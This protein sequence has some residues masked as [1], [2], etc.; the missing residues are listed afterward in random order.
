[1]MEDDRHIADAF[2]WDGSPADS[3]L[4]KRKSLMITFY[5]YTKFSLFFSSLLCIAAMQMYLSNFQTEAM[6]IML[7]VSNQY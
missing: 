6:L 3:Q 5:Y 7:K 2:K 1:M 4:K